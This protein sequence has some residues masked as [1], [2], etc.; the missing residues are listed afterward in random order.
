MDLDRF[1][2]SPIGQLVPISGYHEGKPFDHFAYVPDPLPHAIDLSSAT[3]SAI[4]RAAEALGRLD[5][6][7]KRLP[8]PSLIARPAIRREAVITSALE[9]TYTTLPQVLESEVLEDEEP[10][11]D[12]DEVLRFVRTAELGYALIRERP[13]SL[14]FIKTLHAKLMEGDPKCPED[15]KGD[16]RKSQNFIGPRRAAVEKALFVPPPA[17]DLLHDGLESWMNWIGPD[18]PIP[19]LLKVALGHYQFETLHPFFDGNGRIGRLIVV[20]Q[21]LE[22]AHLSVPL[23]EISPYLEDHRDEYQEGL[24]KLSITG[25]FDAWVTFFV[26]AIRVQSDLGLAKID[27]LL[28]L[29]EEMVEQLREDRIRGTAIQ[30]AEELIGSPV[31]RPSQ[32]AK[33]Y[34]VTY[35]AA[36]YAIARLEDHGYLRKLRPESKRRIYISNQVVEILNR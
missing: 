30:L 9:G 17:N 13:L 35:Q 22:S 31:V 29:K 1:K 12:V 27:D 4:V 36:S 33:R 18:G 21:L 11:R 3:W 23:L 34:G 32:L 2:Q 8:S 16:F 14:N 5:I 25:N 7:G 6:A 10:T 26:E 28:A 15:E 20:L 19:I 24:R